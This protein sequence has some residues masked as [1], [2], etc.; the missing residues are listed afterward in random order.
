M[1]CVFVWCP[2]VGCV[3][4]VVCGVARC[5]V[6]CVVLCVFVCVIVCGCVC[7]CVWLVALLWWCVVVA[8]C[9]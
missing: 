6:W 7:G 1:W 3:L 5:V 9:M 4:R 8:L 2:F